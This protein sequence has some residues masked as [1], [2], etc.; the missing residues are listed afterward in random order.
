MNMLATRMP[1]SS[2]VIGAALAVALCSGAAAAGPVSVTPGIEGGSSGGQ[3]TGERAERLVVRF[4][5]DKSVALRVTSPDRFTSEAWRDSV[6]ANKR[7][8]VRPMLLHAR[9]MFGSESMEAAR[10]AVG[11]LAGDRFAYLSPAGV[12]GSSLDG[13]YVIELRSVRD[14]GAFADLLA[15]SGA[16]SFAE[17]DISQPNKRHGG[18]DPNLALQW[19]IDNAALPSQDHRILEANASGATGEGVVVGVLEAFSGNFDSDLTITN[20]DLLPNYRS[21]LSQVTNPLQVDILHETAVAGLI[22]AAGGNG[23]FG[24]GVAFESQLVAL[25]NGSSL[26]QGEAWSHEIGSIDI[27]NNSWGPGTIDFAA[28]DNQ[29]GL[30][31]VSGLDDFEVIPP[32]VAAVS[33]LT[34]T[35]SIG[36]DRALTLGRDRKGRILV[37][38]A[39]NDSHFQGFDRFALGNA[40]SLPQF[41]FLDVVDEFDD[42]DPL[43]DFLIDGSD[44]A[45]WRYS[46]M[47]GDRAEYWQVNGRWD[48]FSIA[49]IDEFGGRAGYS[50]TGTS[51]FVGGFSGGSTLNQQPEIAPGLGYGSTVVGRNITTTHQMNVADALCPVPTNGLNCSFNGTSAS[52]PIVSGV[53]ALMLDV[54]PSLSIRDIQHILQQTSTIVNFDPTESYWTTLIGFGTPDPDDTP[55]LSPSFWQA[56][57]ADV[58]HSDEYG[59]G[60]VNA[61]AAVNA[62]RTWPGVGQHVILD[63]G[64]RLEIDLEIPAAEFTPI[65]DISDTQ[66]TN[67]LTPGERV[68]FE[69]SCIRQNLIVESVEVTVSITGNSPGDLLIYLQSP[70]GS[71]SPLAIPRN[72]TGSVLVNGDEF[73]YSDFTFTTYKHWGE[74][75]GGRWT[76]FLQDFRP[77]EDSPEGQLPG[78]DPMADPGSEEITFLGTLGLPG[79]PDGQDKTL[80]TARLRIHGTDSDIPPVVECPIL[81][82]ICPGDLDANGF[83]NFL[84]LVLFLNLYQNVDPLADLNGDGIVNFD[85]LQVFIGL[86]RPGFCTQSGLPFNRPDPTAIGGRPVIRPI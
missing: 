16:V 76:L 9:V 7:S 14:A 80:V 1:R 75:A 57:D 13:V 81:S 71:V 78:D 42:G 36:L 47:L 51:V 69:L 38:S 18:T 37:F 82:T 43:T 4:N 34:N 15:A 5:G 63:T 25:R 28:D 8:V 73:A 84:D 54:N 17:V 53:I 21:D 31:L 40:I 39:G 64:D 74:T 20:T 23:L 6:P 19:H 50:T 32:S 77:D 61:E 55:P 65:G 86:W 27:I 35:Q 68:D 10:A 30:T 45:A 52:A 12:Y 3:A 24:R 33:L 22:G 67:V 72:D 70:R 85:D 48:T 46:G 41:G 58:L 56:N 83:V 11:G 60:I 59:F 2:A 29:T 62:A 44:G 26:D 49:A 66:S 79:N